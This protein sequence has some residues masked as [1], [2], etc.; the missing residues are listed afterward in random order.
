MS[1]KKIHIHHI[2]APRSVVTFDIDLDHA[3]QKQCIDKAYEIGDNMG[4]A[5]NVKA[6]MSTYHV[7]EQ[8]DVYNKILTDITN[9]LIYA[10]WAEV[11]N[12]VYTLESAWV[13]IYRD[14][15]HTISHRHFPAVISFCYYLKADES[16]APLVFDKTNLSI[17]P[18]SGLCVLFDGSLIHSVPKHEGKQDR[19]ILAGNYLLVTK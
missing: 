4:G 10:P 1:P 12:Y 17:Q 18:K 13:S 9:S 16:S 15:D 8:T 7:Y 11:N 5:T 2:M 19:L 3:Y 14:G 6:S